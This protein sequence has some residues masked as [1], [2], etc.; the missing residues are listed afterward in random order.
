MAITF[1]EKCY[2]INKFTILPTSIIFM[3]DSKLWTDYIIPP[4]SITSTV[5]SACQSK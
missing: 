4:L 3:F 5:S 1:N 2:S